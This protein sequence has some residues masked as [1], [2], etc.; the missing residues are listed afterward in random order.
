MGKKYTAFKERDLD[1]NKI[2]K[3]WRGGGTVTELGVT[4][5]PAGFETKVFK[6]AVLSTVVKDK[7]DDVSAAVELELAKEMCSYHVTKEDAEAEPVKKMRYFMAS[8]GVKVMQVTK[9]SGNTVKIISSAQGIAGLTA[10]EDMVEVDVETKIPYSLL[11]EILAGFKAVYDRDHTEAACQ[12]YRTRDEEAK[13]IV[14]YPFQEN[15]GASSDYAKDDDAMTNLRQIHDLVCEIH[16]H[17]SM[18]AFFSGTDDA[19]EKIPLTYVVF[20]NFN[21][22]TAGYQGRIRSGNNQKLMA[23]EELFD[24]PE[25]VTAPLALTNLPEPSAELLVRSAK[26]TATS[27][28]AEVPGTSKFYT[29]REQASH[30]GYTPPATG[31]RSQYA[32][33]NYGYGYGYNY[34]AAETKL[35]SPYKNKLAIEWIA[36]Q[37]TQEEFQGLVRHYIT[38]N[39][40]GGNE[41][42][43]SKTE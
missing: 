19:N 12:I 5:K 22:A 39:K 4:K 34:R 25:D 8:S 36:E 10:V 15:T 21:M 7:L 33:D 2:G 27:A 11:R 20:G 23:L 31:F 37:L 24:I 3:N 43:S 16:S 38:M 9:I 14:Y 18:G 1:T 26:G 42:G 30:R 17:S 35:P 29:A 40:L 41:D 6:P 28:K 32:D 13:Y